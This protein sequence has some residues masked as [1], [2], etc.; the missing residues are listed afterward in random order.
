MENTK[1]PQFKTTDHT[2][3][4]IN[5]EKLQGKYV[6]LYFYP[7]DMTPGCTT[8][9]LGFQDLYSEF[10]KNNT[11]VLAVSKDDKESH[12]KF[13]NKH[14]LEF[15]LLLD[16]EGD[17]IKK[18][19]VWKEKSMYG[20]KYMG[21]ARESFLINPKGVIIK[22]WEKVSPATHPQHVLDYIIDIEK[23]A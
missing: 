18:Y 10:K 19:N 6:V 20:K 2:G 21:I 16:I 17:I 9:A 23:T 3:T 4:E 12:E 22:H 5:L 8:E 11:E 14:S 13:C 1:A 7:K 15:P